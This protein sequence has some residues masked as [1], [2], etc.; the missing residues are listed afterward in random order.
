MAKPSFTPNKIRGA[1]FFERPEKHSAK[2]DVPTDI[3]Q[4]RF[5]EKRKLAE[6]INK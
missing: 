4:L 5:Y 1:V 3:K 2:K 6:K